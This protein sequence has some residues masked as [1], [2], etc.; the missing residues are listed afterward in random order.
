M[1][2]CVLEA[3]PPRQK[4]DILEGTKLTMDRTQEEH[5]RWTKE[6]T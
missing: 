2:A 4:W 3:P 5:V 6:K 1:H